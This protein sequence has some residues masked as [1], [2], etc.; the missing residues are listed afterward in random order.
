MQLL[1]ANFLTPIIVS[2]KGQQPPRG[3]YLSNI[4]TGTPAPLGDI[5]IDARPSD[6][7]Q[8][9]MFRVVNLNDLDVFATCQYF[10]RLFLKFAKYSLD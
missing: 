4:L 6:F 1:T 5:M 9:G 7:V 2:P 3:W 8:L 10:L